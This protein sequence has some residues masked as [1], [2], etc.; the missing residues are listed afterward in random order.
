MSE[1]NVILKLTN[2]TDNNS[3]TVYVNDSATTA[4][5]AAKANDGW[6]FKENDGENFYISRILM[7]I[8]VYQIGTFKKFLLVKTKK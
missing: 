8:P 4:K 1:Y 7:A 3:S 6:L 5:F 2:C